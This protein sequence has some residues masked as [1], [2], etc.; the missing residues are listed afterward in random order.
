[1][2]E[3]RVSRVVDGSIDAAW[4]AISEMK[5][6]KDWHPNVANVTV[7]GDRTSGVGAA[8]RVEFHDGNSVVETV[9]AQAAAQFVT[10]S[11]TEAQMMKRAEVTISVDAKSTGTT[12]VTFA[13]DFTMSMG[14]LGA[15]IGAL[16]MKRVFTK[17]FGEAL[18]GLSHHLHT[19]EPVS[20]SSSV[21]ELQ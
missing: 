1:M 8:R 11:M 21:P 6:V 2:G 13:L 5:A 4:H 14:P 20:D 17:V 12:E 9:T 18:A 10:M 3:V 7:L 15:V 16:L 19:G